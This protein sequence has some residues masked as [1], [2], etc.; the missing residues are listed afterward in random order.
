MMNYLGSYLD[1]V[2]DAY[3]WV[4]QVEAA[5]G[6]GSHTHG[7]HN[8]HADIAFAIAFAIYG[9]LFS[10][11]KGGIPIDLDFRTEATAATA[12]VVTAAAATARAATPHPAPHT[13]HRTCPR[14]GWRRGRRTAS[15]RT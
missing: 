9:L 15:R 6:P 11:P 12:A 13:P 1:L 4:E 3:S 14:R 5:G 10:N 8:A 2:Q 7:E